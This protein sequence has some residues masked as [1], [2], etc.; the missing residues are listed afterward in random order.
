MSNFMNKEDKIHKIEECLSYCGLFKMFDKIED[1][2]VY[3]NEKV[4]EY[5]FKNQ[6]LIGDPLK[7]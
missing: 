1:L 6:K 2:D 7:Q 5:I 4:N 3:K